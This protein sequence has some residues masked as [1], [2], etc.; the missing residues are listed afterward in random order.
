MKVLLPLLLLLLTLP[1]CSLF[2]GRE[3]RVT[4]EV[5]S[6]EVI[7]SND[8][9]QR[10]FY[11]VVGRN[12]AAQILWVRHLDPEERVV[13]G[14][15]RAINLD[16]VMQAEIGEVEALVY[17]WHAVPGDTSEVPGKLNNIIVEL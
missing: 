16:E 17:W 12:V 1:A 11:F 5:S 8:T 15:E 4:A 9:S 3:G 2:D 10:V 13:A 14:G 7:I 6:G